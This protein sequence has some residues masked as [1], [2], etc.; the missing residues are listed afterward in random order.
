MV[1]DMLLALYPHLTACSRVVDDIGDLVAHGLR[2]RGSGRVNDL[3]GVE[4]WGPRKRRARDGD[5]DRFCHW[6]VVEAKRAKTPGTYLQSHAENATNSTRS[7]EKYMSHYQASA[8][9]THNSVGSVAYAADASRVGQPPVDLLFGLFADWDSQ[10]AIV[11]PPQVALE[12]ADANPPPPLESR[13]SRFR[14]VLL[15]TALRMR[16][17]RRGRTDAELGRARALSQAISRRC[18]GGHIVPSVHPI[19]SIYPCV[20]N[21]I[22]NMSNILARAPLGEYYNSNI[23]NIL[24]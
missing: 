4:M 7:V 20:E 24:S 8:L 14:W 2:L 5:V 11:V 23:L 16:N 18:A 1:V 21:N 6:G 12:G 15:P 3:G 19:Y 9:L 13:S 17:G 22:N 10:T